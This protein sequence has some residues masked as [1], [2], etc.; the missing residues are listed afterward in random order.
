MKF[1]W[2]CG[3]S[4]A[5][6]VTNGSKWCKDV[7]DEA[8]IPI[9]FPKEKLEPVEWLQ[10]LGTLDVCTMNHGVKF[11]DDKGYDI[12]PIQMINVIESKQH[13]EMIHFRKGVESMFANR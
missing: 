9:P 5:S 11:Y 1:F 2:I 8:Y 10:C 6:L 7:M 13:E 3:A 4:K 12:V